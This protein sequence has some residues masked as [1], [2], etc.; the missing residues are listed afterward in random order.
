LTADEAE[1]LILDE[2]DGSALFAIRF[3]QNAA[4]ALLMPRTRPGKRAPLWLQRLKGRSLLQMARQLPAFP[5]VVETYRECLHDHLDLPR[6]QQLLGD[7]ATGAV[8]VV[9]RRAETPSPFAA[10]LLFGFTAA[11]M[12]DY[13]RVDSRGGSADSM[14]TQLLDQMLK[15]EAHQHLLDPRAIHQVEHRLRGVGLPPRSVEEMAEWLRRLGDLSPDELDGAMPEFLRQLAEQGRAKRITLHGVAAPERWILV[16]EEALYRDAFNTSPDRQG[17]VS[18]V[19]SSHPSLTVGASSAKGMILRR[20]VATHALIGFDDIL[21]RYP[22]ERGWAEAQLEAWVEGGAAIV[23][24]PSDNAETRFA[25]PA[26]LQQVQRTSLA[27]HRQEI[28]SVPPHQF[29]DFLLRWQHRHPAARR[30]GPEGL[31]SVLHRLEALALPAE[32][33]EQ[34]VLPSRVVDYQGGWLDELIQGGE[35]L[36]TARAT[37]ET[38]AG[39]VAFLRRDQLGEYPRPI[40]DESSD[41]ST[42]PVHEYLRQHGASF[43]VD[44]ARQV[45]LPPHRVRAGLWQLL[46]SGLATNDRFDVIRRGEAPEPPAMQQPVPRY[47]STARRVASQ[48]PEGRWSLIHWAMPEPESRAV[49]QARQLLERYGV[50]SRELAAM[51]SGMPA[52]RVLYE[53][54]SR[55]E[56]AGNVRRGCF[57]EGLSGAQFALPEAAQQLAS[58]TPTV[59]SSEPAVLL[60]S[61]DPANLYGS[62]APF[63]GCRPVAQ[64]RA[65]NWLVLRAGWPVLWI[66][67]H[68]RRLSTSPHASPDDLKAAVACLGDLMKTGHGVNLRGKVVVDEWN[69]QPVSSTEGRRLL[70]AAGFVHDYQAMTLYAGW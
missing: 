32:L 23:I 22:F 1:R 11:F 15:P 55:M 39:D 43:L 41:A 48:R 68:G 67:G 44:I 47:R 25:V 50:V 14:D 24:Q 4:R 28:L 58:L 20:F 49:Y 69:G 34:A 13:D 53:V 5:V 60:H 62:G 38:G 40:G 26:N 64:R 65:G 6:L 42:D 17:G 21:T 8:K 54:L 18:E 31:R 9:K 10:S 33:W 45:K 52:W 2:L 66:E 70:E 7:M 56:W 12:Y 51:D 3:R 61:L 36:W 16:E 57:V 37:A 35:W 59:G 46:R 27:L 30:Q 19:A 29:A 63:E